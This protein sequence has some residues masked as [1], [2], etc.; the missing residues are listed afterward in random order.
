LGISYAADGG[1]K[2]DLRLIE[3]VCSNAPGSAARDSCPTKRNES[4]R[5]RLVGRYEPNHWAECQKGTRWV[6]RFFADAEA[7]YLYED[8]QEMNTLIV[9]KAISGFSAFV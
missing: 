4:L 3:L 7:L 1:N 9:G 8:T 5:V 6:A 2:A